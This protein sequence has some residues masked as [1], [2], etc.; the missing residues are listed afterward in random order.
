LLATDVASRGLDVKDITVVLNSDMPNTIEDYV[1]RI[2]RTG[3]AGAKGIAHSFITSKELSL[4]PD[5]IKILGKT[6]QEIPRALEDLAQL[7]L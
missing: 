2:G 6:N 7:S 4:A 5:L 3:R 1:H